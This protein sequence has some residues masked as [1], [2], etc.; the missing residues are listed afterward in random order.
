MDD[1]AVGFVTHP[2]SLVHDAGAHHPER[3]DR[4]LAITDHLASSGTAGRTIP[5][6]PAAAARGDIELAHAP[7]L[8]D[9]LER[10]DTAGGGRIDL[11]TAMG[12]SSLDAT[13]RASQGA[14]DAAAKVL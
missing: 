10:L 3:P 14:I 4:I 11:D 12:P 2:S 8:V 13:L 9:L 6:S 7:A 1:A 5:H